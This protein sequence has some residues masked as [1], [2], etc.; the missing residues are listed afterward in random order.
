M[1][2]ATRFCR[3]NGLDA[4]GMVI[5]ADSVNDS[6]T[7]MMTK[8]TYTFSFPEAFTQENRAAILANT[9]NCYVKKHLITPPE[10]V[11]Q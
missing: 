6:E 2:G 8:L 3:E 7:R 5:E 4:T 10:V 1:S 11:V 9:V